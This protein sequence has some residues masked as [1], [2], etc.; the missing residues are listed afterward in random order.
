MYQDAEATGALL[1]PVGQPPVGRR[2]QATRQLRALL[3][4][5]V[6]VVAAYRVEAATATP[7]NDLVAA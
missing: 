1:S 5:M 6:P 3:L 2:G 7:S 4:A